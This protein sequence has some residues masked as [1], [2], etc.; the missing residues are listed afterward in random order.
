[1]QVRT[2][3][4]LF[5]GCG[6]L[7]LGLSLAGMR[8]LFAIERDG[9]AF[10]T[11]S[12]NFVQSSAPPAHRFKWPRWLHLKD[13]GIYDILAVHTGDLEKLRGHVD[14]LVGR[15]PCKGFSLAGSRVEDAPRQ[16]LFNT[17]MQSV[18][19]QQTHAHL[20]DNSTR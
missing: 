14:I 13:W 19:A 9:M 1:M 8:G 2:V 17:Y 15:P 5:A 20:S 12:A 4:D 10:E 3:V 18:A 11:F 16:P 6:G 7:S